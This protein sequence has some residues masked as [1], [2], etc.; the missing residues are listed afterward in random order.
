MRRFNNLEIAMRFDAAIDSGD[1]FYTD[2]NALSMMQ[3][4]RMTKI[5]FRPIFIPC[6]PWP[7]LRMPPAASLS[8]PDSPLGDLHSPPGNLKLCWTVVSC[9]TTI[10]ALESPSRTTSSPRVALHSSLR[11]N[12]LLQ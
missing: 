7:I 4:R 11:E 2:L 1:V 10:E 12:P 8:Y 6:P 5:P 9:R 3:R